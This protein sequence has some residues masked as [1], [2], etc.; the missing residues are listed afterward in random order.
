MPAPRRAAGLGLDV[1]AGHAV[2]VILA[3]TARTPE[4]VLRHGLDLADPWTRE[5][6]HPYHAELGGTGVS[7]ERARRRGCTAARRTTRRVIRALVSEMRRHGLAA[8]TATVVARKVTAAG[9]AHA[10]AHSEEQRLYLGAVE[11]ALRACGLRVVTLFQ[12]ALR[13][14]ATKRLGRDDR[15][16][17]AALKAFS[18]EVGTPWRAAEKNATLAAWFALFGSRAPERSEGCSP[19]RLASPAR[20]SR[21]MKLG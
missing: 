18:H 5:S 16:L 2:V 19:P 7:G 3:G 1:H 17:A 10:R 11:V 8:S 15:D 14:T 13:E 21:A 9:S 4:I 20:P 12:N 6:R